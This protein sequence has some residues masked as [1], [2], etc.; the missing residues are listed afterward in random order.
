M[1]FIFAFFCALTYIFIDEN[2]FGDNLLLFFVWWSGLVAILH[3]I[4]ERREL[5]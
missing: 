2:I 4:F 3:Y 5:E 1:E